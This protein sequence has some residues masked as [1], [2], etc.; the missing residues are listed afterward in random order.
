[1]SSSSTPEYASFFA[2][3]G[4][5]A[6]MVFSGEPSCGAAVGV[7]VRARGCAVALR[8]GRLSG[9]GSRASR[10]GGGGEPLPLLLPAPSGHR[11]R[12]RAVTSP[13]PAEPP[14]SR[15]CGAG[16]A[17]EPRRA[18]RRAVP[19]HPWRPFRCGAALR[20]ADVS[21]GQRRAALLWDRSL[22]GRAGAVGLKASV[23]LNG[24]F[25]LPPSLREGSPVKHSRGKLSSAAVC[26]CCRWLRSARSPSACLTAAP[27][28][29]SP[30]S[31][32]ILPHCRQCCGSRGPV[33]Q[34]VVLL[35]TDM[36]RTRQTP[37]G[38]SFCFEALVCSA[39]TP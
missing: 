1:M 8:R 31:S 13:P 27:G 10:G 14:L 25:G 34:E 33:A 3:M 11:P 37:A 26:L 15:D 28:L 20:C 36:T 18:A 12:V 2:V 6:A 32:A 23:M 38:S 16:G 9:R 35:S 21:L 24:A 22:H 30:D 17:P 5:S 29:S 7:G 19:L 4:A 39:C